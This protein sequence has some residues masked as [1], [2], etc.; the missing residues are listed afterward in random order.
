MGD[1]MNFVPKEVSK[2]T[3]QRLLDE[4]DR[5]N[6]EKREEYRK[7]HFKNYKKE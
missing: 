5:I 7:T 4:R 6:E 3:I 2:K 1:N